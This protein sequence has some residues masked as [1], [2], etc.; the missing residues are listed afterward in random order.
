MNG[1]EF[2][3]QMDMDASGYLE[4]LINYSLIDISLVGGHAASA[5]N[6]TNKQIN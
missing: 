1:D 4:L 5:K 3:K 6:K 2:R